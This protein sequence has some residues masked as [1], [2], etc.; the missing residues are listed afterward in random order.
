MLPPPHP[1]NRNRRTLQQ[2]LLNRHPLPAPLPHHH[3]IHDVP[4]RGVKFKRLD[5]APYTQ[6]AVWIQG[7]QIGDRVQEG[8]GVYEGR[9]GSGF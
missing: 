6:D 2:P 5:G 9:A 1:P 8:V 4:E 7:H 3:R